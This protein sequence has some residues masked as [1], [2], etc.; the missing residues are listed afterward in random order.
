VLPASRQRGAP[1]VQSTTPVL[2]GAPGF[3]EQA[4][5]ASHITHCPLP[6]QTWLEPHVVPAVTSSPSTQPE[7]DDIPHAT[8]P[9]LHAPPGLV[10]QTVPPAQLVHAP[11]LQ[12]LSGPHDVPSG[13]FASS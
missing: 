8:T 5:P 10:S 9:S 4:L 3:M 2:H 6:L 13:T 1:I 11:A 7:D 12:I